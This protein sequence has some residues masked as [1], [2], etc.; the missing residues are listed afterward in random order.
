VNQIIKIIFITLIPFIVSIV[1]GWFAI[2]RYL[3]TQE[4]S[5]ELTLSSL[6]MLFLSV[7]IFIFLHKKYN[8]K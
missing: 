3:R 2:E 8:K 6:V 7:S 5:V 4:I 1:H